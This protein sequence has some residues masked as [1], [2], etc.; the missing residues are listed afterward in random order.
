MGATVGIRVGAFFGFCALA[1]IEPGAARAQMANNP[2]EINACL[3]LERGV[4]T[5]SQQMASRTQALAAARQRLADLDAQLARERPQVQVNDPQS[6]AQYK[7][8]LDRRDDAYRQ[9][10]VGP[11]VSDADQAV[12]RY[13][14]EANEYNARCA[15][16]PFNSLAMSEM[17]GHLSCPPLP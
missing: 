6:V 3:C 11:L 10:S 7:A 9:L 17:Q 15:N 5:L 13:N 16:H 14:R 8:L 12:S 1:L 2:A 4:E